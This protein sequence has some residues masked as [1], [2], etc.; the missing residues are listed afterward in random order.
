MVTV[1]SFL[2]EI[3]LKNRYRKISNGSNQWF[4]VQINIIL[5]QGLPAA[6][7][8]DPDLTEA[9]ERPATDFFGSTVARKKL[10][11]SGQNC[12]GDIFLFGLVK[13]ESACYSQEKTRC[14]WRTGG[15]CLHQESVPG[16]VAGCQHLMPSSRVGGSGQ[17]EHGTGSTGQG[18]FIH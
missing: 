9:S 12:A 15:L 4:K 17:P 7:C 5:V 10:H 14:L 1:A 18:P 3:K 2:Y 11:D 6:P 16:S 8:L 13:A